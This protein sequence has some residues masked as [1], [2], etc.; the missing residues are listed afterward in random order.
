MPLLSIKTVSLRAFAKMEILLKK[1]FYFSPRKK[2][3]SYFHFMQHPALTHTPWPLH[4]NNLPADLLCWCSLRKGTRVQV[5]RGGTGNSQMEVWCP[6]WTYQQ[7][8]SIPAKL[9]TTRYLSSLK[10]ECFIQVWIVIN[11]CR[12]TLFEIQWSDTCR[13]SGWRAWT[14]ARLLLMSTM[15][16]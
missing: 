7:S 3:T 1:C 16:L 13:K 8:L 10:C 9:A 15:S 4:C 6:H 12:T 11:T 14:T 5:R 2:M